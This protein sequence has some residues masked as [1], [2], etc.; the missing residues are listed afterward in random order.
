[1][2]TVRYR[3]LSA[4]IAL[5]SIGLLIWILIHPYLIADGGLDIL[6]LSGL[7]VVFGWVAITGRM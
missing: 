4:T 6:G 1:M 3:A 7:T 2:I 5:M